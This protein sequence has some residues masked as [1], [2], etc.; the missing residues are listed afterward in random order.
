M[1][2]HKEGQIRCVLHELLHV[3]FRDMF[4]GICEY[5]IEEPAILAWENVI[6]DYVKKAPSRVRA[7][8]MAIDH[9]LSEVDD[10]ED[11]NG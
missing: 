4:E 6:T 9:K 5:E 10:D 2:P 11:E 7:W 1:D 8:R 3:V